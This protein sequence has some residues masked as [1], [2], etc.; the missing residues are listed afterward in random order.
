LITAA[1]GRI[2]TNQAAIANLLSQL[3]AAQSAL[4][5]LEDQLGDTD[6]A[7]AAAKA[8]I[9]ALEAALAAAQAA[10]EELQVVPETGCG[11]AINASSTLFITLSILL[12]AA[13]I[14]FFKK[15]S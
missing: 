2:D 5:D 10:I 1:N 6:A 3:T 4:S 7:L 8:R 14:V 13:L 9:D 11:S 12:G 15:R